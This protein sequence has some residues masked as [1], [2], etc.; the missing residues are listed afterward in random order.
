METQHEKPRRG[1]LRYAT[2]YRYT[3]TRCNV[4]ILASWL[5][6]PRICGECDEGKRS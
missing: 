2:I 5:P 4:P 3:C 6:T 1:L